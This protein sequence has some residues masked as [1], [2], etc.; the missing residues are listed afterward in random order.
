[1]SNSVSDITSYCKQRKLQMQFN[2]PMGN[3]FN[4][5]S[6]YTNISPDK[7]NAFKYELDMR[8]KAE[9]LKHSGPQK[10]NHIN[11]FTKA[12]KYAQII[13]GYSPYQKYVS[14]GRVSEACDASSNVF[15][16]SSSDVPGPIVPLYYD[17]SVP[18]YNYKPI[19][20][21]YSENDEENEFAFRL[22]INENISPFSAN[23]SQNIGALEIL[24]KT[25]YGSSTFSLTVNYSGV[26]NSEPLLNITY[27]ESPV[28]HSDYNYSFGDGVLTISNIFLYTT[29]GY[30]YE[31]FL[32][33]EENNI[34]V[35]G[36]NVAE[37]G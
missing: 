20:P 28:L 7:I 3:R 4:I 27:S 17:K 6:P 1:M 5:I 34:V 9:V 35:N 23:V 21:V 29:A 30:F 26:L 37:E 25:S 31:F 2:V 14:S 16:S 13:R 36:I 8:R 15:P 33:F 24:D 32:Q 18:L 10:S 22:F 11:Q 19:V 12:E